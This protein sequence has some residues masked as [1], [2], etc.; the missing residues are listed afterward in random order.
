M[1][2]NFIAANSSS[3][4][5]FEKVFELLPGNHLIIEANP[6]HFTIAAISEEL[7][8]TTA[9]KRKDVIGK[10]IFEIYGENPENNLDSGPAKL[11]QSLENVIRTKQS[12]HMPLTRYDVPN[13]EGRFE[14]R[15]WRPSN[16]PILN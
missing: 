11:R 10:N 4:I 1:S 13:K 12:E 7:L 14:E 2:T 8:Q 16:K 5:D 3:I 15:Y 6:P 9:K